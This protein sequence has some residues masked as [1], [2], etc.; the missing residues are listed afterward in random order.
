MDNCLWEK[1]VED[2][3]LSSPGDWEAINTSHQAGAG[4]GWN[5]FGFGHTVDMPK[6]MQHI[7]FPDSSWDC[8][9]GITMTNISYWNHPL[10]IKC[11]RYHLRMTHHALLLSK[12]GVDWKDC[13]LKGSNHLRYTI[14]TE[15]PQDTLPQVHIVGNHYWRSQNGA[16]NGTLQTEK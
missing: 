8:P 5:R 10:G 12:W 9:R 11:H 15:H 6:L 2:F 1:G 13:L 16:I 7:L 3:A 4:L 14:L